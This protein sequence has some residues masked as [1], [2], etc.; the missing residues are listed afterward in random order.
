M[1]LV[2]TFRTIKRS[3]ILQQTLQMSPH[4]QTV[5]SEPSEWLVFS[6]ADRVITYYLIPTAFITFS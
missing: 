2:N 5:T 3:D 1:V 4:K 6:S